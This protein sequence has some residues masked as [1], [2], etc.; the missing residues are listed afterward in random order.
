MLDHEIHRE[1]LFPENL[2]LYSTLLVPHQVRLLSFLSAD[3]SHSSNLLT[4]TYKEF[5][6]SLLPSDGDDYLIQ[7]T[8]QREAISAYYQG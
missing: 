2:K 7:H 5:Q 3:I 4:Y 8:E 1:I 6:Q